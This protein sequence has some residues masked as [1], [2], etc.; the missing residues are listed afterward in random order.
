MM[1]MMFMMA[2][3]DGTALPEYR[4]IIHWSNGRRRETP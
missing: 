4:L 3:K 1:Y 2:G